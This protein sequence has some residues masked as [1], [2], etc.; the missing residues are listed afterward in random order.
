MP[1]LGEVV[2]RVEI[3]AH[4]RGSL[5]LDG[6]EH[7]TDALVTTLTRQM[8]AV[9]GYA[10]GRID[11]RVSSIADF[12]R[13]KG[14]QVLELNGVSADSAHIHHP[15]A[16]LID[17]YRAMF[18]QW[19]TAFSIGSAYARSGVP[20]TSARTLFRLLREDI[21]RAGSWF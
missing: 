13:G 7:L 2:T 9:P 3:G 20:A 18:R 19:E 8:D 21:V 5:F 16:P 12:R 14:L 4:S 17:G 11:L 15:G 6:S 1:A 10:L